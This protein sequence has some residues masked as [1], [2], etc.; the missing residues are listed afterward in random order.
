MF[1][2]EIYMIS[3]LRR[4]LNILP[5]LAL[6]VFCGSCNGFFVSNSSIEFVTVTPTS[7]ILATAASATTPGDTYTLASSATTVGGTATVDT[8]TAT[9]TSS[10]PTVV[11]ANA[12]VL[13]VVGATGGSTATITATDGGQSGTSTVLTYTGTA[14]TTISIN[15]PTGLVPSSIQPS[16][17][18]QLTATASLN[19]NP[20]FNLSNFVSWTSSDTSVATVNTN[21]LVTVLS[22]ATIGTTFTITATA[23]FGPSA[24]SA[25]LSETSSSFTI[26]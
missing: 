2:S 1:L 8:T 24:P 22:T 9:W 14:P 5:L 16:Q 7:V 21:G 19:A 6:I 26:I 11:T 10:A 13:T 12:G 3:L 20:S 25:T 4:L 18:I 23:N 17:T 15:L